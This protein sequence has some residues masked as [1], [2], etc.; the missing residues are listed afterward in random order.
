MTI[1]QPINTTRKAINTITKMTIGI[2]C[3]SGGD[4]TPVSKS[5]K[6]VK[7]KIRSHQGET[8]A[9]T[10]DENSSP[11]ITHLQLAI[12]LFEQRP[13]FYRWLVAGSMLKD[14]S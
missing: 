5:K 6:F 12:H 14:R 2:N 4:H 9:E 11:L 13:R 7:S 8:E 10:K 3:H 1:V